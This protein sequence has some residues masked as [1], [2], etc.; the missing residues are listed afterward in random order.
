MGLTAGHL[1]YLND[2]GS[3]TANNARYT[4]AIKSRFATTKAAFNKEMTLFASKLD[5]NL[6]KKLQKVRIW[7]IAFVLCWKS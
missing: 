6:G 4:R 5:L 7:S 3:M 2:L 1:E